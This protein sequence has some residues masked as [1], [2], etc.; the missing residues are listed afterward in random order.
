MEQE[1][2]V[3]GQILD[4]P[5]IVYISPIY[6]EDEIIGS[7]QGIHCKVETNTS[8]TGD[9]MVLDTL[10]EYDGFKWKPVRKNDMVK[11]SL[12]QIQTSKL[13]PTGKRYKFSVVSRR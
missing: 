11:L 3:F 5:Q 1:T 4:D 12:K 2:F 9:P 13:S 7:L 8:E 10:I 6:D